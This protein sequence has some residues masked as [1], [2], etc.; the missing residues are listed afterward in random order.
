M[1]PIHVVGLGLDGTDGL[2][3]ATLAPITQASLLVGSDRHLA[4]FPHHPGQRWVLG[5]IQEILANLKTWSDDRPQET[6]VVFASGDPLFFGLGR[7]LLEVLPADRLTFHP[8]VSAVQLAFSRLKMTWHDAQSL[9][10][11]GRSWDVLIEALQQGQRK[12]AILTDPLH[13]PAGIAQLLRD[14]ALP[15]TYEM[16]VCENLGGQGEA[17]HRGSP[18]QFLDR[19]F[20]SL[21]TVILYL[22]TAEPHP[23][24]LPQP[25]D[26]QT[27]PLLGIP[28]G[29]FYHFPDRPGLM[30]KREIRVQ[31]LGELALCPPQVVWDIGAGTGSV[32]VEISRLC[33]SSQVYAIE[34]TSAGLL[35][36]QRNAQRFQV[37]NLIPIGGLA[38]QILQDL[39][40]PD[41]I[42]IGGSGGHLEPLL[43]TCCQRL[44]PQG[45]I[46]LA[47]ATLDHQA[48]LHHWLQHHPCP[49]QWR[50][51]HLDRSVRLGSLSR[52][53]PLNPITLVTLTPE[54]A[55]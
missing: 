1:S 16:A 35:L 5:D 44:A 17:I 13:S 27:L 2:A 55:I 54:R 49:H 53:S 23:L 45:R 52:Y 7:L 20:A 21:S 10:I 33:P 9:S 3:P 14:L 29:A 41:R 43:A 15:Q 40:Q 22:P 47:L 18:E 48:T 26:P 19:T 42:F 12:L 25:W 24:G 51:I 50:Q 37:P 11:H 31:I 4:A 46:V 39:P 38:P 8:H 32:A 28:D 34:K 36:I 30:T 6:A